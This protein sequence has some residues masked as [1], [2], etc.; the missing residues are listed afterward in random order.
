MSEPEVSRQ[1]VEPAASA[2]PINRASRRP[3][4]FREEGAVF[5]R[6]DLRL[7]IHYV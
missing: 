1:S 5:C 3:Q 6:C 4:L 2:L 7:P